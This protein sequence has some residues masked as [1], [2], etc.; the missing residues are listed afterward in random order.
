MTHRRVF[1]SVAEYS[2]YR[3]EQL[4]EKESRAKANKQKKL[5]EKQRIRE[6][7]MQKGL[8]T[9]KAECNSPRPK[10]SLEP[11]RAG[12]QECCNE[13][14]KT[15]GKEN[16][17]LSITN[18]KDGKLVNEEIQNK[19]KNPTVKAASDTV[20]PTNTTS[21]IE[22][23]PR[24]R[25]EQQFPSIIPRTWGTNRVTACLPKDFAQC[26]ILP[27]IWKPRQIDTAERDAVLVTKIPTPEMKPKR[28][29]SINVDSP[30]QYGPVSSP[31]AQIPEHRL[32]PFPIRPVSGLQEQ[33]HRKP[34]VNSP[35][36]VDSLPIFRQ[37]KRQRRLHDDF[38][39]ITVPF[40]PYISPVLRVRHS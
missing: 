5:Q 35:S 6:A 17:D 33:T 9:V 2:V 23:S 38:S 28:K 15:H 39:P 8:P 34:A 14:T 26:R 31:H 18:N 40:G 10:E 24:R 37:R 19:K 7:I 22:T 36:N 11:V 13:E 27:R 30:V 20:V 3:L 21:S 32:Q 1:A 25:L 29:R 16:D 4:A 12:E